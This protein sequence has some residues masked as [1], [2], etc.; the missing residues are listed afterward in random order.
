MSLCY[1]IHHSWLPALEMARFRVGSSKLFWV[2]S[3]SA[4]FK[5]PFRIVWWSRSSAIPWPLSAIC[6][7]IMNF[8]NWSVPTKSIFTSKWE[9]IFVPLDYKQFKFVHRPLLWYIVKYSELLHPPDSLSKHSISS[10]NKTIPLPCYY[11]ISTFKCRL[12]AIHI[13]GDVWLRNHS[14]QKRSVLFHQPNIYIHIYIF[15]AGWK[16]YNIIV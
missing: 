10:L 2:S 14:A 6:I 13:T 9:Q 3:W 8:Q 15:Y 12:D 5:F 1:V 11:Q 7:N 4:F 16:T